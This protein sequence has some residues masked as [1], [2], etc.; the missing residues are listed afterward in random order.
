MRI[1]KGLLLTLFCFS[2]HLLYAQ[3]VE[4]RG[5]VVD[6]KTQQ[7][8]EGVSVVVGN[9]GT[10][11]DSLGQFSVKM[12]RTEILNFSYV[13]YKKQT[14]KLGSDE[15][16][17]TIY[18]V[19]DD[20][21]S[22]MNDVVVMGFAKKSKVLSTGSSV[23]I[24]SDDIK[25]VPAANLADLL[26]GKVPGVNIQTNSGMPGARSSIF[27]RGLSSVDVSGSGN[28]AYLASTQPLIII[29]GVPIDPNT[30]YEYGFA[31]AGAGVSPLTLIPAEDIEDV[32]IL[33]D[34]AAISV[35]GSRGAYG[36]WIINTKKG[37]SGKPEI[38]YISNFF[39]STVPKLR[40]IYGGRIERM[41]KIDQI[42]RYN[43]YLS[44]YAGW[45]MVNANPYLSDSL[46]PY[47]NNSTNWQSYFFKSTNNQNHNL[48]IKGG[49]PSFNYKINLGYY[50][51]KGIIENTGMSR[52]TLG[53]NTIYEPKSKKM[54]LTAS[55]NANNSI[56]NNGSGIGLLQTGVATSGMASTT[57]PPP[58]IYTENSDALAAF[59]IEEDNKTATIMSNLQFDLTILKNLRFQ[60]QG[61]HSYSHSNSNTFYPS[62]LNSGSSYYLPTGTNPLAQ[63]NTFSRIGNGYYNRNVLTYNKTF[64][65]EKHYIS[66][67][68]F[69]DLSVDMVRSNA[70]L[71]YG[72][73]NDYISGPIGYNLSNSRF[74]TNGVPRNSRVFG[75]GGNVSYAY[76]QRYVLELSY[77]IDGT[78][79]NGPLSGYSHNPTASFK[80]NLYKEKFMQDVNWVDYASFR[81]SWG[82][83]IVPQGDVYAIYGKYF[84]GGTYM[85]Q[86][87]VGLSF[88]TAPNPYF[89]PNT[90]NSWNGG[91]EAGF[92]KGKFAIEYDVYYRTVE[93]MF[94]K[95]DIVTESGYGDKPTNEISMVNYGHELSLR[96]K[97]IQTK[98]FTWNM[99]INGAYNKNV[100][101]HLPNDAR[102]LVVNSTDVLG[103][104][105]LYRLGSNALTNYMFNTKGVYATD[106]DVP[107]HPLT[108]QRQQINGRPLRGGDP[109]FA[110]LN[111]DYVI[112]NND[113]VAV[114]DPQPKVTGGFINNLTYKNWS[115]SLQWS[116]TLFRDVLNTPLAARFQYFYNPYSLSSLPLIDNYNYWKQPGDVATYPNPYSYEQNVA[117][118]SYRYNQTLF[119]EDGSYFKLNTFTLSYSLN[120]DL[121]SRIRL[122]TARVFFT[123]Y[124]L[125]V[126]S[127]YSGPNPENVSD[128]GRDQPNGYPNPR[129]FS[130]GINVTL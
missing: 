60:A 6:D 70:L 3:Q 105:V 125:W 17:L 57:L 112:D 62:W 71:L 94:R 31:T 77:R 58:S 69:S 68:A 108:G 75:Y 76:E 37:R 55:I 107:V 122:K 82:R 100:L 44:E 114:G 83:N 47:L 85:G 130:L 87:S 64:N 5:K 29:D 98:N 22:A 117:I 111:G 49:D 34:A 101:T 89:L 119:M 21:K 104:P 16:D 84:P 86:P 1:L 73:P 103:L 56:R 90:S 99:N 126:I 66:A 88:G 41:T 72:A 53:M 11:T 10:H 33:K 50:N 18:L 118:G 14:Y 106:A 48:S 4:I 109:I 32:Q 24:T 92:L 46:N 110:D 93:N 9:R 123:G 61:S 35:Y 65:Q 113:R 25:D 38:N 124:N 80:W 20:A 8:I 13:E 121:I 63:Y 96:F 81:G 27:Q 28:E 2:V 120:K 67:Y 23:V 78:S 116:Y 128:L 127:N 45:A 15:N 97:P 26:Q 43:Q 74:G 42:L 95:V 7:P 79:T 115:M 39:V 51:E 102:Q 40:D 52:Y 91:L 19:S 12:T 59:Q 36:V 54:K 30:D 129:K